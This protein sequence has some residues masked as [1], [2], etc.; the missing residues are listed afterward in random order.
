MRYVILRDDDTNALTPP[1][2]LEWLYRPFLDRGLPVNLATIPAVSLNAKRP[3]GQPESFLW[4]SGRD[5]EFSPSGGKGWDRLFLPLSSSS[6]LIEYLRANPG[7]HL[8]Q[9]GYHHDPFEFDHDD[10]GE[11]LRRIDAGRAELQ[12]AGFPPPDTFVAPHD[13]FSR[14][15]YALLA[16]QFRI[17]STGWF[18]LRRLP[19]SWWPKY[20]FVKA[21]KQPHWRM[22]GTTL[23]SHPG[24]LLS[25]MRPYD[26]MLDTIKAHIARQPLTVLVTHWWE[27]FRDG[28]ADEPFIAVLHSLADYLRGEKGVHM[29]A[30]C[31][32]ARGSEIDARL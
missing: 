15:S 30:F 27:Y 31:Q 3:D 22:N 2:C 19:Y 16:R 18:E 14:T 24:C 9:H 8:V 4:N 20:A 21:R 28:Q 23:L 25:Y 1:E 26:S 29:V 7:F 6:R 11:I 12:A 5:G 32:L 17:I 10:R 13:K